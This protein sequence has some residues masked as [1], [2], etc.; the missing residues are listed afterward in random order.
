MIDQLIKLVKENAGEQIVKNPAIPDQYNNEAIKISG[1]EIFNGLKAQV[2]QGN[3]QGLTSFFKTGGSGLAGN[4][5]VTQIISSV[6]GK[7]ASKFGISPAI[8]QQVASAIVPTVMSK[9]VSKT[10][11]P[12]DNDFN[13]SDVMKNLGGSG[14][15]DMLGSLTGGKS[16]GLGDAL[17]GF[18]K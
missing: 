5:I 2:S 14:V 16:G 3:V 13:V 15:G 17:G 11:D 12:K 4:P 18:F 6:A 7:F 1:E 9:F 8:A 10:N